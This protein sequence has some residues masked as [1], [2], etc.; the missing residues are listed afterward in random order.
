MEDF[1]M[2]KMYYEND[3]DLS[4]LQGKTLAIIGYGSQGHAQ[5]Q[6]LRDSGL[7]VIIADLEG[8]DNW[9]LAKEHDEDFK[10]IVTYFRTSVKKE[11]ALCR[12]EF[13]GWVS[14]M[15]LSDGRATEQG[16]NPLEVDFS[17]ISDA[18]GSTGH[19]MDA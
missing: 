16:N 4:V 13:I 1:E 18:A 3:A 7:N 10:V 14:E 5:G 8:S 2:A 12:I 6:N 19:R 11:D 17:I 15:R 9:K